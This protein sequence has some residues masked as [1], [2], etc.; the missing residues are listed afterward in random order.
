MKTILD[1]NQKRLQKE[2]RKAEEEKLRKLF[3][4]IGLNT[5]HLKYAFKKITKNS[6]KEEIIYTN[7]FLAGKKY[8]LLNET[9]ANF[10]WSN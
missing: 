8:L 9:F 1:K 7:R 2:V 4:E 5:I 6:D 10:N 3:P